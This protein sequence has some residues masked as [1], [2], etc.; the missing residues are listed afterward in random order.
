[1]LDK[2]D[3]KTDSI[4]KDIEMQRRDVLLAVMGAADGRSFSP[5]QLQKAVFL[6]DRNLPE[7]FDADSRFNFA[8]YDYGPFDREVYVEA[9]ALEMGNLASTA[10]GANGYSEYSVTDGGLARAGELLQTLSENQRAYI[11]SVVE[12]VR[13]LG[14]A[15]LVKSIYEAYPDMR[16]NS[17]FVG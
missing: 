14:F 11:C 1:M 16:A 13:S 7:L 12:W 6:I 9:S 4:A 2:F 8:P 5:V 3:S 10:K 15:K 17:V